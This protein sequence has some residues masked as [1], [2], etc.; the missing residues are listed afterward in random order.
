MTDKE[1]EVKAA[2]EQKATAE[3]QWQDMKYDEQKNVSER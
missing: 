2:E 1:V 3:R